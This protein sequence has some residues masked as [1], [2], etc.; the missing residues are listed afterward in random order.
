MRRFLVLVV[1][2]VSVLFGSAATAAAKVTR[3]TLTS[4]ETSRHFV[5]NPPLSPS[6]EAPPSAGDIFTFTDRY[7]S[8]G[9]TVGHD[10][11]VC[12]VVDWPNTLCSLSLFLPKGHI[13]A[14]D[15]FNFDRK[16]QTFAIDGGT[17]AYRNARGQ[18]HARVLNKEATRIRETFVII[19]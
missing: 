8:R 1:V 9:K 16:R 15:V 3:F 12:V 6:P 19:T 14:V 10:R 18:V 5:D 4:I 7:V 11:V 2:A 13:T 17:G